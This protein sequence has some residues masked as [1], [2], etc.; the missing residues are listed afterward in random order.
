MEKYNFT[1]LRDK[2]KQFPLT[3][4]EFI[5][6]SNVK[7]IGSSFS[8]LILLHCFKTIFSSRYLG[9]LCYL[10]TYKQAIRRYIQPNVTKIDIMPVFLRF[11]FLT[12]SYFHIGI[13]KYF[14]YPTTKRN[15]VPLTS[16]VIIT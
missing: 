12:Q 16:T 6:T 1:L 13:C 4:F 10:T 2:L 15:F 14:H 7:F 8:E 3:M 5:Y 9:N 11:R